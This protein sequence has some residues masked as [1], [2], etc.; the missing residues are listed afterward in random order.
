MNRPF[1]RLR[2][3]GLVDRPSRAAVEQIVHVLDL[4]VGLFVF[5]DFQEAVVEG[6]GLHVADD[7]DGHG[8]MRR[9]H[10]CQHHVDARVLSGLVVDED[11]LLGN[12]VFTRFRLF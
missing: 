4:R 7:T 12:A 3:L 2:G 5:N 6:R 11:V 8:E 1:D 9:H 10:V